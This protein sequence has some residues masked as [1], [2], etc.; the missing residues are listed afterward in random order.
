MDFLGEFDYVLIVFAVIVLGFADAVRLL[1]KL[2]GWY[3]EKFPKRENEGQS[4]P[5]RQE[6]IRERG[7]LSMQKMQ[8][9]VSPQRRRDTPYRLHRH[10]EKHVSMPDMP[11]QNTTEKIELIDICDYGKGRF[12]A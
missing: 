10:G 7:P 11:Q 8:G 5:T 4:T 9:L 6:K 2:W 3:L 12:S 1:K